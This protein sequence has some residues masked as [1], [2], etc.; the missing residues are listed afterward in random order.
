V[1]PSA[2]RE[3]QACLDA[4]RVEGDLSAR[5]FRLLELLVAELDERAAHES[6]TNP[7]RR[8]VAYGSAGEAFVRATSILHDDDDRIR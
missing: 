7:A 4:V 2:R 3:V 8:T 5:A 6:P 1:N